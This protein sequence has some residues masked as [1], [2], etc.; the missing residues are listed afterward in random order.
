MANDWPYK[1]IAIKEDI[2]ADIRMV[3]AKE[4]IRIREVAERAFRLGLAAGELAEVVKGLE[5]VPTGTLLNG[6]PV[7]RC[8]VCGW[9]MEHATDCALAAALAAYDAAQ[10]PQEKTS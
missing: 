8:P 5:F 10:N 3:A 7:K 2:H 1:T 4:G 9:T 6:T